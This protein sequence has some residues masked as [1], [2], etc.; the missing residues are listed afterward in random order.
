MVVFT[1]AWVTC[2]PDGRPIRTACRLLA[3]VRLGELDPYPFPET[4]GVRWVKTRAR[5]QARSSQV[6]R[7]C[8]GA[9]QPRATALAMPPIPI[10]VWP[11]PSRNRSEVRPPTAATISAG[12][13]KAIRSFHSVRHRSRVAHGGRSMDAAARGWSVC[14]GNGNARRTPAHHRPRSLGMQTTTRHQIGLAGRHTSWGSACR[15]AVPGE[16]EV[17]VA[18]RGLRDWARVERGTKQEVWHPPAPGRR[19]GGAHALRWR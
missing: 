12:F 2:A 1:S 16:G 14:L 11:Y 6:P 7:T 18:K 3:G 4:R 15:R 13:V 10:P 9:T 17:A 8:A 19:L 5:N